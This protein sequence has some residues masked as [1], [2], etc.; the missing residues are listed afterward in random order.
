M[1]SNRTGRYKLRNKKKKILM[2]WSHAK[3]RGWRRTLKETG[4][5][6]DRKTAGADR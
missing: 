6:E 1:E 4:R 5:E 3:K 2:D